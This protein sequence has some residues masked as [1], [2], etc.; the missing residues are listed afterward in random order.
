VKGIDLRLLF[1]AVCKT[2]EEVPEYTGSDPVDP[3]VSNLLEIH[4]RRDPMGHG[5]DNLVHSPFRL[6]QVSDKEW[7]RDR[8][9]CIKRAADMNKAAGFPAWFTEASN[10]YGEDAMKCYNRHHRPEGGCIDFWD[11]SKRIGRPTAEGRRQRKES[12]KMGEEDP[13][14]CQWCPVYSF[15][16]TD[17]NYRAG[18]Y[19]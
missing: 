15:V 6:G 7:A 2:I 3:L 8:D 14:L 10:T 11:D 19:S 18:L 9:G 4:V 17:V 13:H 12:A 5:G 16:Q 1:C